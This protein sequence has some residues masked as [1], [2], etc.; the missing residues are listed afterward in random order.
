MIG[1]S[2][3]EMSYFKLFILNNYQLAFPVA[4]NLTVQ[5]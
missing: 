1:H 3:I 4:H 5:S 2:G